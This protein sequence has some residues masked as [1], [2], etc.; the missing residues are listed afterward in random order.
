[1]VTKDYVLRQLLSVIH[2]G[3]APRAK[4]NQQRARRY[5]SAKAREEVRSYS[6]SPT[7]MPTLW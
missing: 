4:M 5:T 6:L 7:T 3:V 2:A 1:M